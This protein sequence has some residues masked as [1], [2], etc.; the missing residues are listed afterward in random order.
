MLGLLIELSNPGLIF[1]GVAGG[2][3]LLLSIYSLGML[4]ANYA[5]LLLILLAFGLFITEI[6]T[7]SF[8]LLFGGG[9]ISLVLGSLM[10]FSGSSLEIDP[11]LI[12]TVVIV[13]SAIF[14]IVVLAVIRAHK[15]PVS[16][17][18]EG[19]VGETGIAKTVLNPSGMVFIKGERWKA[20]AEDVTIE[21]GE[22]VT[23]TKV[24]GL[25]LT[26][27]KKSKE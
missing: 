6:F 18:K 10:L 1:P 17:G 14:G 7:S 23:V 15:R 16:T 27:N 4:E 26:V 20:N 25:K 21:S 9:V 19:L 12:A 5:G 2:V 3:S 22:E 11:W 24:D 13:F 8:G